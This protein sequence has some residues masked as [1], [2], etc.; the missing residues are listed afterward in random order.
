MKKSLSLLDVLTSWVTSLRARL[1]ASCSS[2]VLPLLHRGTYLTKPLEAVNREGSTE[3]GLA[4]DA[5]AK[6]AEIR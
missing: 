1:G 2:T 3:I 6:N 4:G 5:L